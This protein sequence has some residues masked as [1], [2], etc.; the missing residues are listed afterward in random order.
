M[1]QALVIGVAYP[2]HADFEALLVGVYE[3]IFV[4]KVKNG[5]VPRI[6]DAIFPARKTL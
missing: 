6:G 3:L 4:A 1:E 5:F 2:D